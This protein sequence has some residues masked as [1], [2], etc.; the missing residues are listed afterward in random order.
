M[1]NREIIGTVI[2]MG[3]AIVGLFQ[4]CKSSRNNNDLEFKNEYMNKVLDSIDKEKFIKM[5]KLMKQG[6]NPDS[7][8]LTSFNKDHP[9]AIS[10]EWERIRHLWKVQFIEGDTLRLLYNDSGVYIGRFPEA[11]SGF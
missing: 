7:V 11:N 10:V 4:T 9:Q 1:G 6:R 3:L 5:V 2:S 8:L